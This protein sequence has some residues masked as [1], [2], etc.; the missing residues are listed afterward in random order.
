M[1][2]V[3]YRWHHRWLCLVND[4]KRIERT[5]L[6][7]TPH[8]TA[9]L[10]F[11]LDVTRQLYNALLEERRDAYRKLRVTL[12]HPPQYKEITALRQDDAG[13]SKSARADRQCPSGCVTQAFAAARQHGAERYRAREPARCCDDAQR[14]GYARSARRQR[15]RQVGIE[16]RHLGRG[17]WSAAADDR[18]QS[19]RIWGFDRRGRPQVFVASV[20]A[21][22][23][24]RD[25]E[26]PKKAL[27]V[28]HVWIYGSRGRQCGVGDSAAGAVGAC[29]ERR[30]VSRP[31]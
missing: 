24:R 19:G 5:R 8:Q 17:F 1:K 9:Q 11:M 7:P 20:F 25:G 3:P 6:Y 26:P 29:G 27:C 22:R 10:A 2:C 28:R 16:S 13:S 14:E 15:T 23:P 21:M 18:V 4:M 12:I 31:R 30:G